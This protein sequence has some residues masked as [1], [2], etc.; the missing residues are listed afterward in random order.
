MRRL[1][2]IAILFV[3][4]GLGGA[5]Y[6]LLRLLGI[7]GSQAGVWSQVFLV[8]LLLLWLGTYL[9][10][11]LTQTMTYNQQLQEYKTAV[12]QKR[13]EAMT[14]EELAQLQAE[15]EAEQDTPPPT[16]PD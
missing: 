4:L 2:A 5:S 9:F 13:L 1:D 6:G 7:D 14:P 12:L 10:R 15:I 3:L 8:A 11:V 16:S